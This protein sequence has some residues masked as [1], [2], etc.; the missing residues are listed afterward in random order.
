MRPP[1]KYFLSYYKLYILV[2]K[3]TKRRHIAVIIIVPYRPKRENHKWDGIQWLSFYGILLSYTVPNPKISIG[4][5]S[6]A[7]FELEKHKNIP[8]QTR[9]SQMG[10]YRKPFSSWKSTKTYRPKPENLK[11]DGIR[12]HFRV[13]KAQKHTV[14]NLKIAFGTVRST[15]KSNYYRSQELM[16]FSCSAVSLSMEM[17]LVLRRISATLLSMTSGV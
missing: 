11:W 13:G 2:N 7:V 4:T 17:P 10:R 5:V 3:L 1:I 8:S 15:T 16:Y 14:P 6:E 9:K 12:N